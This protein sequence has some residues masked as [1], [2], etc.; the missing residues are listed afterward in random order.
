MHSSAF[1]PEVVVF[2]DDPPVHFD[3]DNPSKYGLFPLFTWYLNDVIHLPLY[4]AQQVSVNRKRNH[5]RAK[6]G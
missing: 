6:K 1:P 4:L 3:R 2:L 5:K